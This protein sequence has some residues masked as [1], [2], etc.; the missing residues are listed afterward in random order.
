MKKNGTTTKDTTRWRCISRNCGTST[1]KKRTDLTHIADFK[2]F[3][4]YTSGNHTLNQLAEARRCSRW[5]LNRTFEPFWLIDIP[6][7]P[8]KNRIYDQVFIDGT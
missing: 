5:T 7:T 6:N 3:I 4:S 1:T 2:A 8:D